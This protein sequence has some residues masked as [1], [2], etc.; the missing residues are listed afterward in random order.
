MP[1]RLVLGTAQ[2]GMPHGINNAVGQP[3]PMTAKGIVEEAFRQGITEFDTAQV[4]GQSESILGQ[5]FVSLKIAAQAGVI[6]KLDPSLDEQPASVLIKGVH[7]SIDRLKIG[8]LGVLMLHR[9]EQ[10][11]SW[12]S[13]LYPALRILKDEGKVHRFGVSVYTP[14]AAKEAL[15]M[16]GI[17]CVQIPSSILDK[18]FEKAG[19]FPLAQARGKELYVRSVY[20]QGLLLMPPEKIPANMRFAAVAIAQV[21]ALAEQYNV[22]L[23]ELCLGYAL[24]K[25]P[26]V[27]IIVGAETVTQVAENAKIARTTLAPA[28]IAN[29]DILF[30]SV[31]ERVVNPLLWPR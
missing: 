3:D 27:K 29:A 8:S 1:S 6:T 22:T 23:R 5:A 9:Q 10:L 20:L 12:P 15:E 30:T 4:Y 17:D 19:I 18:R 13:R 31:D 21:R 2:L 16:E 14:Q 28:L 26:K 11:A 7:A 24:S 25:W